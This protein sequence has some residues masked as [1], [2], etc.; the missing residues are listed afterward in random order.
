[1]LK[2]R[3]GKIIVF[4]CGGLIILCIICSSVTAVMDSLGLIPTSTPT[5]PSTATFTPSITPT[6]T[7][8][9]TN[10]LTPIPSDTP[11]IILTPITT[12]PNISAASCV[13]TDTKR[14]IGQ[15]IQIIDGDTITVRI[16]GSD[17][18]VRYIGM[19]TSE[20]GDPFS[21]E[22]TNKNSELVSGKSVTLVKDISETDRYDRLLRYI[23]VGD[24][25]V[26]YELVFQG[27]A[28]AATFPPDVACSEVFT[29]AQRSARENER[30]L[31]KPTPTP[32]SIAPPV[33][34]PPPGGDGNVIIS[35]IYYDGQVPRVE[36]DEYAEITN[37]GSAPVDLKG[38]TLN[39]GDRGQ[40]FRFPSYTLEPG[41]SCRVY[42]N[43]IHPESCGFSFRSGRAIWNNEGDCGYLYDDEGA[44]VSRKCY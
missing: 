22:A 3:K 31:W 23:F 5:L 39:A 35:F 34:P 36:S 25:F 27:Y 10:T 9:S 32:I 43:E 29:D 17:Y 15:V 4:G 7:Q 1:M 14:E 2:T 40:D 44:L 30:G 8:T 6:S 24:I 11:T 19:D 20:R 41:K 26:N 16:D 13:P 38:W 12:L 28:L 42:T 33:P 18:R 21:N 37:T